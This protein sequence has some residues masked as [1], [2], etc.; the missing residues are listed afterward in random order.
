MTSGA[1]CLLA[2]KKWLVDFLAA[3]KTAISIRLDPLSFSF[4][5]AKN[6]GTNQR[7]DFFINAYTLNIFGVWQKKGALPPPLNLQK[8][9]GAFHKELLKGWVSPCMI[10]HK[11]L[12][13]M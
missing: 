3:F 5:L 8:G 2:F 6:Q 7:S 11:K 1:L 4:S 12:I 10:K 13:E 9:F